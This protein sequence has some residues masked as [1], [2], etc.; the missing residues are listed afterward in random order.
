MPLTLKCFFL[1][2]LIELL[3]RLRSHYMF[4]QL[5]RLHRSVG[6]GGVSLTC[7]VKEQTPPPPPPP[8]ASWAGPTSSSKKFSCY[9]WKSSIHCRGGGGGGRPSFLC[10]HTKQSGVRPHMNPTN[11]DKHKRHV[12]PRN[13]GRWFAFTLRGRRWVWPRIWGSTPQLEHK[14]KQGICVHFNF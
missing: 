5:S 2:L 6:G 9:T 14:H 1:L 11:L 7:G 13:R 10:T 4:K 3:A 8:P 12:R